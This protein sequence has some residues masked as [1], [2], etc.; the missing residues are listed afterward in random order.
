MQDFEVGLEGYDSECEEDTPVVTKPAHQNTI[1][2]LDLGSL[3]NLESKLGQT[4][5]LTQSSDQ[6]QTL[7]VKIS[8]TTLNSQEDQLAQATLDLVCLIDCSGSMNGFKL[9][10][11]QQTLVY[12]MEILQ[13]TDRMAL[14]AFNSEAV[15][16]N[17][18]RLATKENKCGRLL[19]NIQKLTAVGGTNIVGGLRKALKILKQRKTKN[20]VS[21]IFLLGDGNDNFELEGL[22]SLL[23]KSQIENLTIHTFGY[24]E[25]HDPDSLRKIAEKKN[26]NFY[27]IKDLSKVDEAF[28]DC[29]SLLTS[30]IGGKA[31]AKVTLVPTPM[32]K[33]ISFRTCYGSYWVGDEDT[34]RE[35]AIGPIYIGIEKCFLADLVL[36]VNQKVEP[37]TE[38]MIKIAE[39]ELTLTNLSVEAK[40]EFKIK[41]ELHVSV[42]SDPKAAVVQD[43]EVQKHHLRVTGAQVFDTAKNLVNKGNFADAEKVFQSFRHKLERIELNDVVLDNLNKHITLGQQYFQPAPQQQQFKPTSAPMFGSFGSSMNRRRDMVNYFNENAHTMMCEQSAPELYSDMYQNSRQRRMLGEMKMKKAYK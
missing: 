38:K 18:L 31:T 13:P 37:F 9:T 27:F 17:S 16:L 35:I 20:S 1:E 42:V 15:V 21:S 24:G 25:D 10:Q 30:A 12:M 39:I 6:T 23:S 29:L 2:E 4:P 19:S 14:V 33:E 40:K 36:D 28:I 43:Q 26:G 32:F 3:I 5:I 7:L 22:D 8:E 34:N 41:K 11:V